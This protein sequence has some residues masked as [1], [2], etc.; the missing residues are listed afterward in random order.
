M[1]EYLLRLTR[2]VTENAILATVV[3]VLI[4]ALIIVIEC[5]WAAWRN[6]KGFW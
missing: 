2:Q 6:N 1:N 3:V 5:L 4:L